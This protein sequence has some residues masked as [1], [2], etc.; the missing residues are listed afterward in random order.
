[1]R[2]VSKA[3]AATFAAVLF[4]GLASLV[5]RAAAADPSPLDP[6]TVYNY[7]EAETP[8]SA[9]MGGTGRALGYGT[10]AAFLDPAVLPDV[11]VYHLEALT[12]FTPET[13]RWLLG[14]AV[15]DSVTSRLAGAFT[16]VGTPIAMDPDGLDRSYLDMR[17]ALGFPITERLSIGLAGRYLKVTQS[18]VGPF[19][20]S[21]VSGGLEDPTSIGMNANGLPS[22][23]ALVNTVSFDAGIAIRPI[24]SLYFAVVGQNLS[25]AKNG[26]LPML[27]GG[28]AGYTADGLSIEADALADIGSYTTCAD[29][30]ALAFAC[31]PRPVARVMTGAEYVLVGHVPL[32]LGYRYDQGPKLNTLSFGS[33][34]IS[35]AFSVEASFKRTLSSPGATTIFFSVAYFLES[36][37][38]TR[39]STT[40][41][42]SA[43]P[44][45]AQ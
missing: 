3:S 36:S 2:S 11:R 30:T 9:G 42:S 40:D 7:G 45:V 29:T 15:V 44:Q 19:G 8:R 41:P 26:F 5:P 25:Y 43:P 27:V 17:L 32:R 34:F 13:R 4:G 1:M 38:L 33:G 22:R 39:P 23:F 37:G 24:D 6:A 31:S 20:L 28:G 16:I 12:S 21:N 35:D 18:G 10:T 14:A